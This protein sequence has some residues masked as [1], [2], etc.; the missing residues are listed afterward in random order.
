LFPGFKFKLFSV[1][2]HINTNGNIVIYFGSTG[3]ASLLVILLSLQKFNQ[4]GMITK[5]K[6][7]RLL[8]LNYLVMCVAVA[9]KASNDFGNSERLSLKWTYQVSDIEAIFYYEKQ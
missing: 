5:S 9:P 1:L 6:S 4:A 2:Y 8:V 7:R 3:I